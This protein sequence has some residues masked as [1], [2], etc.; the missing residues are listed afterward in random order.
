MGWELE[1]S[2]R[3]A[4]PEVERWGDVSVA[5]EV[6]ARDPDAALEI[7]SLSGGVMKPTAQTANRIDGLLFRMLEHPGSCKYVKDIDKNLDYLFTHLQLDIIERVAN[8]TASREERLI[9]MQPAEE[10]EPVISL[11]RARS[12]V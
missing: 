2:T 3:I 10:P 11:D 8:D 12:S 5:P 7:F 6:N 1:K 4:E 9:Q